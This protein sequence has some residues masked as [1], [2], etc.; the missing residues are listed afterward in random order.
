MV[1]DQ[2]D[3]NQSLKSCP[4]LFVP[5]HFALPLNFFGHLY[6]L[7]RTPILIC[8]IC[9]AL[10]LW[11]CISNNIILYCVD[12]YNVQ[13]GNAYNIM[14]ACTISRFDV[15]SLCIIIIINYRLSAPVIVEYGVADGVIIG[16]RL[17]RVNELTFSDALSMKNCIVP[18]IK[19]VSGAGVTS[20]LEGL[21]SLFSLLLL[22]TSS[23]LSC[24]SFCHLA[25]TC[26]RLSLPTCLS[27]SFINSIRGTDPN[28]IIESEI[29]HNTSL[30]LPGLSTNGNTLRT[31]FSLSTFFK[32]L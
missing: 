7:R 20:N 9:Q 24:A 15:Q 22:S 26:I 14:F 4:F 32:S 1:P 28:K 5:I 25:T 17:C 18:K 2:C 11:I 12:I 21:L 16:V 10:L 31:L 6:N 27:I 23:S 3:R 8:N 19:L 30:I 13:N 29:R